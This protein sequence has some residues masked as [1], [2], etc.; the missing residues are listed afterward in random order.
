MAKD[1]VTFEFL[2]IDQ[3]TEMI[4]LFKKFTSNIPAIRKFPVLEQGSTSM[5]GSESSKNTNSISNRSPGSLRM[6]NRI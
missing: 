1:Y 3:K 5:T 4:P 6:G 2:S